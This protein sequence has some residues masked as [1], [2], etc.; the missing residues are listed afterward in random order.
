MNMQNKITYTTTKEITPLLE[1]IQKL[2]LSRLKQNPDI[3]PLLLLIIG[4]LNRTYELTESAIWGIENK[5][6]L[7]AAHMARALV[8]TLGFIYFLEKQIKKAK[9]GRNRE[10]KISRAL[11]G[12]RLKKGSPQPINVLTTIDKATKEY[13]HLR[14]LYNELSEVVHPNSASH[15]YP[16]KP[17]KDKPLTTQI[18]IPFYEFKGKDK[19]AL[20]N[21]TG[22]TCQHII[23]ICKRLIIINL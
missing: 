5:R 3:T 23:K 2:L 1:E 13:R 12:S 11:F 14:K 7:T 22:E 4:I 6:P 9:T 16:A 18:S 8:E 20:I 17:F 15:F 19:E 10:E 21:I